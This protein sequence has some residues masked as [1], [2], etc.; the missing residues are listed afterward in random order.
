M[1]N[2]IPSYMSNDRYWRA[3]IYLFK[4]NVKLQSVFTTKYFDLEEGTI[5]IT[6]LKRNAAPW[7]SSEKFMLNLALHLFNQN[8]KVNLSDMD[9]LD[10]NNKKLAMEAIRLRFF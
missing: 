5:K 2:V 10:D 4:N 1:G 8:N 6:A 7:S 3:V 9:L